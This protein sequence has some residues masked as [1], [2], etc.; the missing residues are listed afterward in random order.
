MKL[1][2]WLLKVREFLTADAPETKTYLGTDSPEDLAAR[3]AHS[4]L[5]DPKVRKAL[6][7]GGLAAIKTSND[8]MIKFVL[9]TDGAARAVRKQYEGKVTGPSGQAAEK[10]AA[11][12]FAIYG[13]NVYPDATFTPRLSYGKVAGWIEHG[14]AIAPFTTFKGLWAR[15]TSKD[16]FA[17]PARWLAAKGKLND[18]TVFNLTSTNDIIGG[19]SGSPLITAK[20]EVI[21]AVFDG[22][23]LSLGGDYAF[24][25]S[26]NR[27]VAVSTAAATEALRKVYGRDALVGELLAP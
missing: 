10:I 5:A 21:G 8:P 22:N 13:T 12:R 18:A 27:T 19:N 23:I 11:A 17:L 26:V 9:A 3:L 20:G 6:W 14:R 4:T 7:D 25:E 24:D 16:P 15:V 1:E 2:F